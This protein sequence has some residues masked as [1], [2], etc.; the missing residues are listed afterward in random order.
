MKRSLA[1]SRLDS[2]V[3]LE[4]PQADAQF[5]G[6]GSGS[7]QLVEEIW[8]QIMD[9]LPSRGERLEGGFSAASRPARVRIRYRE[10]VTPA[11][12]LVRGPRIMQIVSMPA[13]I[14][15]RELLE[16]M[17]EDYRPAGNPA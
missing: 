1:A 13:E 3:R 4:Q 15:R 6:A 17:V 14:G 8:A 16:F 5:D 12:R 7:W 10:D 9:I 11:M 2:L